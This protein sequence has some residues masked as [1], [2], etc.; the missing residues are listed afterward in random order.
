MGNCAPANEDKP[1]AARPHSSPEPP[2][3]GRQ[4]HICMCFAARGGRS[5]SSHTGAQGREGTLGAPAHRA[6]CVPREEPGEAEAWGTFLG[7]GAMEGVGLV[8]GETGRAEA[9]SAPAF[10][11]PGRETEAGDSSASH[12]RE[13]LQ[14]LTRQALASTP[15]QQVG[16]H[17]LPPGSSGDPASPPPVGLCSQLQG[18]SAPCPGALCA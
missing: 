1:G 12:G 2:D 5:G 18:G 15:G 9:A 4:P 8:L 11:C 10:S 7:S 16:G 14:P 3:C 6:P 17:K 13:G